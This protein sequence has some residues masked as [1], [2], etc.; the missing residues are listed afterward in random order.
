MSGKVKITHPRERLKLRVSHVKTS[1]SSRYVLFIAPIHLSSSVPIYFRSAMA[2][3]SSGCHHDDPNVQRAT[4]KAE[5]SAE[6]S[7]GTDELPPREYSRL[8]PRGRCGFSCRICRARPCMLTAT[9]DSL[10]DCRC[11]TAERGQNCRGSAEDDGMPG[12]T[13]EVSAE[14]VSPTNI[15]TQADQ[16][17]AE[18]DLHNEY[19]FDDDGH[20]QP[21][22]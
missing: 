4:D 10:L 20:W 11:A 17:Q 5:G 15:W 19:T 3:S 8:P 21:R 14:E 2:A 9:H 7:P 6:V 16:Q 13:A 1:S 18:D 22:R 12:L